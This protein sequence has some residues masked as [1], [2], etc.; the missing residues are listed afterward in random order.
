MSL[1]DYK[2]PRSIRRVLTALAPNLRRRSFL[3]IGGA[4]FATL[5]V[6]LGRRPRL[7]KAA[8]YGELIPDPEGI[9]DLPAGFSYRILD[10]FGEAMDDGYR[11]PALPDGMATFSG[12]D[13]NGSAQKGF[14]L[15]A[16]LEAL[17]I[18]SSYSRPRVSNDNPYSEALFRT[19]KY[20]PE[21]P[22][23]GFDQREVARNWVKRFVYWYNHEHRHSAIR[24][25][26]PAQRHDG[27]DL[28]VLEARRLVYE[29]AKIESPE[30][31]SGNIRNW[32]YI[33]EVWLNP[34]ADTSVEDLRLRQ[35]A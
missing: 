26:T 2:H 5:L 10:S 34:P 30:R 23:G 17:G 20:R 35:V 28:Q 25:V 1:A 3:T 14:T 33:A 9:L 22:A 24:F 6:Q 13:A 27:E 11:V 15:R 21:Y 4:A 31:W 7:A 32:N 16:K 12:P 29:Q 18:S 8:T 19:I